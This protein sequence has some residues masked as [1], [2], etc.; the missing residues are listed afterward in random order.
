[1]PI[2]RSNPAKI[3]VETIT[4]FLLP[5]WLIIHPQNG[6]QKNKPAG[7]ANNV[8]PRTPSEICNCCCIVGILEAQLAKVKPYAKKIALTAKRLLR[9]F[10]GVEGRDILRRNYTRKKATGSGSFFIFLKR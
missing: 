8:R 7:R 3:S 6:R 5:K 9:L 10:S 4:T 2:I 1:M